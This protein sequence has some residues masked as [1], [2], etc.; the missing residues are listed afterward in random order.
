ME[1][2]MA[3]ASVSLE[4]IIKSSNKTDAFGPQSYNN[5]SG[6]HSYS[7]YTFLFETQLLLWVIFP[8]GLFNSIIFFMKHFAIVNRKNVDATMIH[9]R[10]II[11]VYSPRFM[12]FYVADKG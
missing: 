7:C 2:R 5:S 12:R 1:S 8:I 3:N 9:L 4:I 6:S 11:L 10:K